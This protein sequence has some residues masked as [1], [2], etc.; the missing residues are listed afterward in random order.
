MM[1]EGMER[2]KGININIQLFEKH[3]YKILID[4]F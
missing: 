3:I 2:L 1:V 4:M